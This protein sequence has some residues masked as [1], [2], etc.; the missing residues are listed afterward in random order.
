MERNETDLPAILDTLRAELS[1]TNTTISSM[2][3]ALDNF[4]MSVEN[5]LLPQMKKEIR[6][7]FEIEKIVIDRNTENQ[8][9]QICRLALQNIADVINKMICD[10]ENEGCKRQIQYEDLERKS[11]RTARQ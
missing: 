1:N 6:L 8:K 5:D 2:V 10:V 4:Q 3:E 7:P 11:K 9:L